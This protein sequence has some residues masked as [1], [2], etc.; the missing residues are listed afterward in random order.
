AN[1]VLPTT[2]YIGFTSHTGD[3]SDNHDI[4]RVNTHAI[5]NAK[6]NPA[7]ST[8][9][10]STPNASSKDTYGGSASSKPYK[11][12]QKSS[13]G[14]ISLTFVFVLILLGGLGAGGYVLYQKSKVKSYKR[15]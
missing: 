11:K 4:I 3:A 10:S 2:G 1:V 12:P 5:L 6:T 14:G 13:G 9:S 15:F 8:D 7:P